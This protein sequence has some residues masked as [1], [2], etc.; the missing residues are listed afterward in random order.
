MVLVL[1][2]ERGRD[3]LGILLL[4]CGIACASSAIGLVY[5]YVEAPVPAAR[6]LSLPIVS[7]GVVWNTRIELGDTYVQATEASFDEARTHSAMDA[8]MVVWPT[9]H[10]RYVWRDES[11]P[12]P[13][14]VFDQP[15][16]PMHDDID[17]REYNPAY[18]I[19]IEENDISVSFT[20]AVGYNMGRL[21]YVLLVLLV[22]AILAMWGANRLTSD[23]Y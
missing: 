13:L 19:N 16:A 6:E 21:V 11:A 3:W 15:M 23:P 9:Y 18:T 14:R 8:E 4:L 2:E 7:Q 10:V 17:A 5:F 1:N 12:I 22:A 20:K